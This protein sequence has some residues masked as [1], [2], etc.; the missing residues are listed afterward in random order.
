[1][2]T[3]LLLSNLLHVEIRR[4]SI[5]ASSTLWSARCPTPLYCPHFE[6]SVQLLLRDENQLVLG[7]TLLGL[8]AWE[9]DRNA[10]LKYHL[11]AAPKEER[12]NV[13]RVRREKRKQLSY[14]AFFW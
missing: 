9:C 1:M 3:V 7:L 5:A 14:G 8:W 11:S 6:P 13:G 12:G 2:V 4:G 10:A